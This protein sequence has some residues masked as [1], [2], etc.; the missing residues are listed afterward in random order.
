MLSTRGFSMICIVFVSLGI[1]LAYYLQIE[2]TNRYFGYKVL[3]LKIDNLL[4]ITVS[5]L[6]VYFMI[7]R[8]VAKPSDFFFLFHLTFVIVPYS[9]LYTIRGGEA[10]ST[11]FLAFT[12]LI[13]PVIAVRISGEIAS[14]YSL[15][16]PKFINDRFFLVFVFFFCLVSVFYTLINPTLSAGFDLDTSYVRRLQGRDIYQQGTVISYLNATVMNGFIPFIAFVGVATKRAWLF[17]LSIVFCIVFYYILGVKSPLFSVFLSALVGFCVRKDRLHL[18][19]GVLFLGLSFLFVVFFVEYSISGYSIAG[20]YIV[21]RA[22]TVPPFIMSA[23]FEFMFYDNSWG[24]SAWSGVGSEKPIT[25]LVGEGFLDYKGLNANTNTFLYQ[26]A[27]N[28]VAGYSITVIFV[29]LFFGIL[30]SSYKFRK[31]NLLIYVGFSYSLLIVEKNAFTALL[32]SGMALLFVLA[33]V[34]GYGDDC[35]AKKRLSLK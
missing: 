22:F 25:F 13:I 17:F 11:Y 1:V 16:I 23:Y 27:S 6:F 30:D 24:W 10:L 21:R 20:D 34:N 14:D 7:P 31:N 3:S 9:I 32:S 19:G 26:L 5:L 18:I 2:E 8:K 4:A 15:I 28:G 12:V 29:S 33:L 35:H